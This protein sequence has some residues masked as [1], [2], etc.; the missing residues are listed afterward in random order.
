MKQAP[1]LHV[2]SKS[3]AAEKSNISG[4]VAAIV[5][6]LIK[7]EFSQQIDNRELNRF[8]KKKGLRQRL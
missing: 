4:N 2:D 3:E 8:K 1:Y 5:G 6:D 7:P